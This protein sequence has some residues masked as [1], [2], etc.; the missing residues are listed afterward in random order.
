MSQETRRPLFKN[1]DTKSSRCLHDNCLSL[2][3]PCATPHPHSLALSPYLTPIQRRFAAALPEARDVNWKS[4]INT[5]HELKQ[6]C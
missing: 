1:P 6:D 5:E 4:E 2:E 3:L